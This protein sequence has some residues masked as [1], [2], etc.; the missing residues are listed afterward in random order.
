MEP[1]L[2]TQLPLPGRMHIGWRPTR[3]SSYSTHAISSTSI[4]FASTP[5]V[6]VAVRQTFLFEKDLAQ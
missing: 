5:E 3:L 6:E 4:G 1:S 2:D